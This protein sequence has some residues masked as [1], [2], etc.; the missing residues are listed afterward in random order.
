MQQLSLTHTA[1]YSISHTYFMISALLFR[2]YVYK[3]CRVKKYE[4]FLF[5]T[6]N[7]I[8]CMEFFESNWVENVCSECVNSIS[9]TQK[10]FIMVCIQTIQMVSKNQ[11]RFRAVIFPL[12]EKLSTNIF[13]PAKFFWKSLKA[14]GDLFSNLIIYPTLKKKWKSKFNTIYRGQI[15]FK[16]TFQ[17]L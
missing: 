2:G 3:Y 4:V 8:S 11:C 12:Y 6:F 5:G 7:S 1:L 13:L 15:I 9:W 16:R 17:L 10:Y 14:L